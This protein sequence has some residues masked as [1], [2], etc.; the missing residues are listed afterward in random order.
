MASSS[1]QSRESSSHDRDATGQQADGQLY[2]GVVGRVE[3]INGHDILKR[4]YG[5][6][7]VS[8]T[9]STMGG[10]NTE[11]KILENDSDKDRE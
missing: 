11:P 6:D 7:G 8:P 2:S 3:A 10:G 9:L 4:I 5:I 1:S